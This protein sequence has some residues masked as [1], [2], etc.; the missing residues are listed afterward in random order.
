M[1]NEWGGRTNVE[2]LIMQTQKHE[3]TQKNVYIDQYLSTHTRTNKDRD[4][5]TL[6]ACWRVIE[7][8]HVT[9]RISLYSNHRAHLRQSKPLHL[10]PAFTLLCPS[11]SPPLYPPHIHPMCVVH[12]PA[13]A[14]CPSSPSLH[15]Y[16]PYVCYTSPGSTRVPALFPPWLPYLSTSSLRPFL[17]LSTHPAISSQHLL[18]CKT[19]LT[20]TYII[21]SLDD[22]CCQ[23]LG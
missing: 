23:T 18:P 10:T 11:P 19:V 17:P 22:Q 5:P 21:S 14:L 2:T 3:H 16:P 8:L 15:T 4:R 12:A 13:L 6:R 7:M 20:V 9:Y 1:S